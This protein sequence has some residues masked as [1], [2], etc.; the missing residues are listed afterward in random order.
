M[1]SVSSH[2]G[3]SSEIADHYFFFLQCPVAQRSFHVI[4]GMTIPETIWG[5]HEII[6]C[7]RT[8]AVQI[9]KRKGH[10]AYIQ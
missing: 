10:A 9:T 1:V 8:Y 5:V 4:F 6:V 3:S 7:E 2:C